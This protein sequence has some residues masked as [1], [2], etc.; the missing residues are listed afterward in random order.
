MTLD[1]QTHALLQDPLAGISLELIPILQLLNFKVLW[2]M[3]QRP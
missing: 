1:L 2:S 3:R